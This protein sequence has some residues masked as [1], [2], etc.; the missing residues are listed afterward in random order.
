MFSQH[1]EVGVNS[2]SVMLFDVL[3]R[4][5]TTLDGTS[6]N[7][8]RVQLVWTRRCL[9]LPIS[10]GLL[11]YRQGLGLVMGRSR[12]LWTQDRSLERDGESIELPSEMESHV[13]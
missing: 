4:T 6:S 13:H 9:S 7:V 10:A 8:V 2:R 11:C 5:R 3:D 12:S 1:T